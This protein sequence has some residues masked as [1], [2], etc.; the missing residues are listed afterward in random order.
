MAESIYM[1]IDPGLT[2]TGWGII[3]KSGRKISYIDS[4]KIPSNASVRMGERLNRI[5]KELRGIAAKYQVD[6]CAVESGYVGKSAQSALKLGQ[7][8]AAAVLAVEQCG[9]PVIDISP[10]E[11]KM[12]ITG[13]GAAAKEQVGYMVEHM[14]RIKFDKGEQDISDALAI[15]LCAALNRLRDEKVASVS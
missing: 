4:G 1:G 8:R 10:R 6:C 2:A 15:A 5:F 11:V 13:R 3:R 7:A 14:L 9:I 12:A